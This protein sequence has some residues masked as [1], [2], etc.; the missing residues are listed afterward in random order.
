M[1][2]PTPEQSIRAAVTVVML[3]GLISRPEF[4]RVGE[5]STTVPA[6]P[7][8]DDALVD[9]ALSLADKVIAEVFP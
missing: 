2:D 6:T 1:K 7:S 9:R 3:H 4:H 5:I 8:D